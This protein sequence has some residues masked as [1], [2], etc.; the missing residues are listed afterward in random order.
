MGRAVVLE[1]LSRVESPGIGEQLL[2]GAARWTDEMPRVAM[3]GVIALVLLAGTL[4]WGA[5]GTVEDAWLV[6]Y[7]PN[8]TLAQGWT[9]Q[10]RWEQPGF[11]SHEWLSGDL[12]DREDF[13]LRLH[14]CLRVRARGKFAFRVS[15]DDG[16]R[17]Y[18]GDKVV[19]DAWGQRTSKG[20]AID[21]AKGK[22]RLTIE[23]FNVS[24][25]AVLAAEMAVAGV[26]EF[27]ALEG[28]AEGLVSWKECE[29]R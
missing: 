2:G 10:V 22:H 21:L 1:D 27:R 26:H 18:V 19:A 29:E 3:A 9:R 4:A 5:I 13:S 17:L 8:G 7:Y 28:R 15:G 11:A 23:Y 20:A 14:G 24:G 6:E 25:A 12:V 16:A